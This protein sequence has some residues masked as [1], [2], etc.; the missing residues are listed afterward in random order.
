MQPGGVA[1]PARV[2]HEVGE[3]FD[4]GVAAA[5]V[6]RSDASKVAGEVAGGEIAREGQLVDEARAHVV[7]ALLVIECRDESRW[8]CDPAEPEGRSQGLAGRAEVDNTLGGVALERTDRGAVIAKLGVVVVLDDERVGL[9]CPCEDRSAPIGVKR[10]TRREGMG[11]REQHGGDVVI[12]EP[13]DVETVR[14]DRDGHC[15]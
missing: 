3:R 10:G 12:G 4:G 2:G 5:A 14:V 13:L 11:R 7:D 1:P 9:L 6:D 15:A 8:R